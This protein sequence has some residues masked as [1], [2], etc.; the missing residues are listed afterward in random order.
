MQVFNAF[1]KMCNFQMFFFKFG[2][3]L[4]MYS[5]MNNKFYAFKMY[6]KREGLKLLVKF[7]PF[8]FVYL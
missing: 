6:V 8:L 5:L 7:A 4:C 2:Q 3:I 1:I